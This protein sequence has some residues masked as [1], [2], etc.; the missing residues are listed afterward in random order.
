MR[1]TAGRRRC[2]IDWRGSCRLPYNT[3]GRQSVGRANCGGGGPQQ[4]VVITVAV[5]STV[6]IVILDA[7]Y[8]PLIHLRRSCDDP[9]SEIACNDDSNGLLSALRGQQLAPGT[10]FLYLD[11]FAG[12]QGS[13]TVEITIRPN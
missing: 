10:Y 4:V 8:D 13:G 1:C 12:G 9:A 7:T 2:A 11:G 3:V 6:D 5:A